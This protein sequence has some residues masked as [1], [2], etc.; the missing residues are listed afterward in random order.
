MADYYDGSMQRTLA[1]FKL[2]DILLENKYYSADCTPAEVYVNG[3]YQGVYLLCEQTQINKNRVNIH[4]NPENDHSVQTGYL[5]IG[6]GGRTDEPETVVVYPEIT[7]TDRVGKQLYYG[8]M[9]FAL[10]GSGYTDEQKEYVSNYVSGVFKVMANAL[11]ENKYYSLTRDGRLIPKTD[12][13]GSTAKEKQIETIDA[14]FN[15]DS[16]VGMCI[17]DELVKNLDAMTFNMYVDLSPD[18]D[19]RLT[20]AAP[21]DF[22]FSMANTHYQSTH[23][24]SGFYATNLSESEGIRVNLFYVMLGRI[25]WFEEMICERWRTH[26]EQIKTIPSLLDSYSITYNDAYER[27][28]EKWGKP[29]DRMLIHHHDQ[30]DL[31]G[32]LT[33]ADAGSFV[34]NWLEKRIFWLNRQWGNVTETAEQSDKLLID[35][36][37]SENISCL[38]GFNNCEVGITNKGLFI[39]TTQ[40]YDPYFYL[41]FDAFGESFYAEDY[42][43]IEIEYQ[44]PTEN[45]RNDY[46]CELFLCTGDRLHA[47]G[48]YS[49]PVAL[50][51]NNGQ[52]KT[53]RI[54]L[55]EYSFW[56]GKI[57]KI[58]I[59][60]FSSCESGD[61]MYIKS[62][63][64]KTN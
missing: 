47:E 6:Q 19:G 34:S 28:Y 1:T 36:T 25:D 33:H 2:A 42:P 53:V 31:A 26:Y 55:S 46:V 45:K 60:Y 23:S 58:R 21:W 39:Q 29:K 35:F 30:N 63:K 18:G 48:G 8:A 17:L 52:M 32:F 44:M 54:D 38:S 24:Y 9:N 20:L 7:V 12:F 43:Y 5:L 40:P 14:V 57:N 11:Y 64:I 10:S 41:D 3:E 49:L 37:Q 27:D 16:A 61:N 22:D 56:E 15:I 4:E 59:D 13:K 50:K 51:K 62:I